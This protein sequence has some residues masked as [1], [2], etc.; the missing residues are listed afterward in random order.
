MVSTR[1]AVD[2]QRLGPQ[3]HT[4]VGGNPNDAQMRRQANNYNSMPDKCRL[5]RAPIERVAGGKIYALLLVDL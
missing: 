4:R 2:V 1:Q 5:P 3:R